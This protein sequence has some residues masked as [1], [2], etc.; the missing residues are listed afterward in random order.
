MFVTVLSATTIGLDGV[1]IKVEVDVAR[2]G[3]PK[4]NVVGLP[5]QAVSEAKERVR[6]AIVNSSFS[7]PDSRI[8]VNLAP[9]DIPKAGSG[10]DL[11]IAIGI[12]AA[13]GAINHDALKNN[14]FVG[15]LSLVGDLRPVPGIISIA[16][17]ARQK[18]IAGLF[19]PAASVTEAS[20]VAG[21]NIYPANNIIDFILHLNGEHKISSCPY[22]KPDGLTI[23][24]KSRFLFEDI[25]G[26]ETA[27]RALT[28]AAAGFHNA[29]LKGPPGAGKTLLSRAFPS[30][31]PWLEKQEMVEVIKIYSICGLIKAHPFLSERPFRSPHHTISRIGLTGGGSHP[32]PGEISLAHRGVLF[33]DEFPEF[34]HATLEALRQP[35]EDGEITI[36][37]AE[38]SLDFPCRFILL[39]ASNPCPCGFLGHPKKPCR[40]PP[41]AIFKYKKRLSG[42]LLDRI[43]IN[44]DVAPVEEAKLTGDNPSETSE[45]IRKKVIKAY[46]KQK[47]RFKNSGIFVNGEMTTADIKKHCPLTKEA[48]VLLKQ[49]INKLSIS[50]RA[51]FKTIKIA[52]TV[53]DLDNRDEIEAFHV[54]EALQF[55][56]TDS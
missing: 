42:P 34:S 52:R 50:A 6:A 1:L 17:L 31:L 21:I 14:I 51:Y 15:E 55:R 28:I 11:P 19:I 22:I 2:R 16:D 13:T 39:A 20:I 33:L 46:V 27:K 29:H 56:M 24:E 8:T 41:G 23:K 32:S 44:V 25:K 10:F 48:A 3:F 37:R 12:L 54:A 18:N 40:C 53:A 47:Q 35:M 38:G 4:F 45:S 9:A 43:D 36:S 26:Q 49:A 30:I 7:M 5:S